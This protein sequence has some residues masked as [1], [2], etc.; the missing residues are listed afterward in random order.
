MNTVRAITSVFLGSLAAVAVVSL[1]SALNN[2]TYGRDE[3][4][5]AGITTLTATAAASDFLTIIM[6][7]AIA[8]VTGLVVSLLAAKRLNRS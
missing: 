3:A 4:L 1:A 5:K 6:F 2:V 8:A 7:Y